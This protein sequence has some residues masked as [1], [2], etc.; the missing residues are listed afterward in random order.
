MNKY[1]TA[2]SFFR[3]PIIGGNKIHLAKILEDLG[4]KGLREGNAGTYLKQPLVIINY[5]NSTAKEIK[6][7]SEKIASE[8]YKKT[9]IKITPEIIFVGSF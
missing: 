6:N 9:K 8:V 1:G 3:N 5:E 2:G 7:F 4:M